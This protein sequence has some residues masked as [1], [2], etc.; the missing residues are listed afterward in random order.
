MAAAATPTSNSTVPA[1]DPKFPAADLVKTLRTNIEKAHLQSLNHL[2]NLSVPVAGGTAKP[3]DIDT[4]VQ[5]VLAHGETTLFFGTTFS[6]L[7]T[8][9]LTREELDQR[10]V[11]WAMK[12]PGLK[13]KFDELPDDIKSHVG[14]FKDCDLS[15]KEPFQLKEFKTPLSPTTLKRRSQLKKALEEQFKLDQGMKYSGIL[16]KNGDKVLYV[17]DFKF[18]N[19]GET[20]ANKPSV[21]PPWRWADN[22]D[23]ICSE[24]RGWRSEYCQ[25]C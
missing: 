13:D 20:V 3:N 18:E 22:T 25:V 9:Q 11:N 5:Q 14:Q 6:L 10:M 4:A 19:W 21:N 17:E 2:A 1:F 16:E 8:G 23:H 24:K 7:Q 15:Q 12:M